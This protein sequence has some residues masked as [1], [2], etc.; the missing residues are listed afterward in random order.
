MTRS[1]RLLLS[2]GLALVSVCPAAQLQIIGLDP[3]LKERLVKELEPRFTYIT[4]R[5]PATWRADDA[6]FFLE[7]ALI[8]RGY[9]TASVDWTLPGGDLI[10]LT[11]DSGARFLFG[12]ISSASP[13]DLS[14]E[15]LRE[16]F[17]QPLVDTEAV[18]IDEAPYIE[19]YAV[20]GAQNVENYLKS[21]GHWHAQ[22]TL[23]STGMALNQMG[24]NIT[25]DLNAGKRLTLNKPELEGASSENVALFWP[26]LQRYVGRSA[27][28]K[29]INK[30]KRI[31]EKFY[32]DNGYQFAEVA[33]PS[34]HGE[35]TEDLK[36]T[37][38]EGV[39]YKVDRVIV[40]GHEKTKTRKIA[41]YFRKEKG[42][43][44]DQSEIDRIVTRLINTGAFRSLTLE[45]RTNEKAGLVDLHV[46]VTEAK[47]RTFRAYAGYGNFEEFI[48]GLGYTDSNFHGSLRKLYFGAEY[49][50]RGLLGEVGVTEPRIF[51]SPIDANA[52]AYLIQRFNDGYDVAKGGLEATFTYNP[53]LH[54]SSRLYWNAEYA[55]SST[56]SLTDAE[57]GPGDYL[58]NRFGFEQIVDFRDSKL[59][60]TSGYYGRALIESG[61]ISGDATNTYVRGEL[62]SS[63][64]YVRSKR[65]QFA[66]RFL[67]SGLAPSNSSEQPIDLRLFSGGANRQRAYEERTL[68]P[69]SLSGD[70]LGGEAYWVGSLEY[71]RTIANPV[72]AIAFIDAGQLFSELSDFSFSDPSYAAGLGLRIDLPI[73]PVRL[74]YGRNLNRKSGEPSGAFHFSIGTSF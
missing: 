70:P 60:P 32:E 69:Q 35:T 33:M 73:G 16:Y 57:L 42:K 2:L 74:E 39:K 29:N 55:S 36:F 30:V 31:V 44:Y 6:A 1:F 64:R 71:I 26:E 14:V 49:S 15:T 37:I 4:D 58:V 38:K 72:R 43:Y 8:R 21:K 12:E 27:S 9:Y 63:Y 54:L 53:N 59:T 11:V 48:L 52:R 20:K 13:V 56:T 62:A 5:D 51:N 50:G 28:T 24:I 22:V 25:L 61:A 10:E 7:R 19:D 45:P 3:D 23:K 68:G 67:V 46:E 65:N 18:H 40:K 34:H 41:R 47:A 66:S 17:L